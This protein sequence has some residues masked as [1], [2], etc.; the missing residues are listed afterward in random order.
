MPAG[1]ATM[2]GDVRLVPVSPRVLVLVAAAG[3]GFG[4]LYW[5]SC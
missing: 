2:T 3:V 5:R 4:L 1:V